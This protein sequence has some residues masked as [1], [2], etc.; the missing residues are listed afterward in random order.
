MSAAPCVVQ[1]RTNEIP[2]QIPLQAWYMSTPFTM[3]VG[4]I[5]PFG[6]VRAPR[7]A[8][9]RSLPG[10]VLLLLLLL[11]R[12]PLALGALPLPSLGL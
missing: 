9:P 11:P 12:R 3:L 10:P 1:V 4:G 8:P 7:L 5:L 6:A 2:R